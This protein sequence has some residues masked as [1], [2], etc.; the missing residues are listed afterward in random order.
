M[1][2]REDGHSHPKQGYCNNAN[3]VGY[4]VYY[5]FGVCYFYGICYLYGAAY[6]CRCH[7]SDQQH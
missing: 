2:W 7:T 6:S 1:S 4:G 3:S 5:S